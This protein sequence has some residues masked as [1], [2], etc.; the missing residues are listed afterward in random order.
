M[1][2]I[3]TTLALLVFSYKVSVSL[4]NISAAQH[5]QTAAEE[6]FE[7]LHTVTSLLVLCVNVKLD[8]MWSCCLNPD[9]QVRQRCHICGPGLASLM[10]HSG[11]VGNF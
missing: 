5:H 4:L 8:V 1:S 11:P 10:V 3:P 6:L 7:G 9:Q 2:N